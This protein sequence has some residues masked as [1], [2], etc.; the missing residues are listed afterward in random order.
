MELTSWSCG[1]SRYSFA[2][3]G[4]TSGRIRWGVW[5]GSVDVG[6]KAAASG[7]RRRD[8]A[9]GPFIQYP[10]S[11][12]PCRTTHPSRPSLIHHAEPLAQPLSSSMGMSSSNRTACDWAKRW[13]T[14]VHKYP[15]PGR[16]LPLF[17]PFFESQMPS[18]L[19][20]LPPGPLHALPA[21]NLSSC[22]A[23]ATG[24]NAWNPIISMPISAELRA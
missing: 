5:T 14:T 12:R 3:R 16:S 9:G 21:R 18:K 22:V 10:M 4:S 11:A 7:S 2:F 24:P 15:V 19:R 1:P 17:S 8:P 13:R 20:P 23:A 6:R